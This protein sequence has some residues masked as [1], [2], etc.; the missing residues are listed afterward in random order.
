MGKLKG[1]KDVYM[2]VCGRFR[3]PS[4]IPGELF[5]GTHLRATGHHLPY[6]PLVTIHPP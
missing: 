1:L 2:V 4:C 6:L 3:G 5:T